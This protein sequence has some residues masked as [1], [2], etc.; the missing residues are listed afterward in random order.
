MEQLGHLFDA[1][2]GSAVNFSLPRVSSV[3]GRQPCESAM[4][5]LSSRALPR[6]P[7][8]TAR[9]CSSTDRLALG[10]RRSSWLSYAKFSVQRW[11]S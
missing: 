10:R 4:T 3:L 2:G 1:P 6:L 7:M 5:S 9:T 11:R 8:A